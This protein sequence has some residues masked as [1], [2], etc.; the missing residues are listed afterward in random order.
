MSR[1]LF[2]DSAR[3]AMRS[4]IPMKRRLA[5]ALL[6]AGSSALWAKGMG[7]GVDARGLVSAVRVKGETVE[8]QLSGRLELVQFR[9]QTRSTNVLSPRTPIHIAGRQTSLCFVMIDD[10]SW[11]PG[12][13]RAGQIASVLERPAREKR[14]LRIELSDATV[15][16]EGETAE[17][18]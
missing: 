12:P 11:A 4:W 14:P 3:R 17:V 8:F 10:P 7:V 6:L 2:D 15:H 18:V 9:G 1:W 16:F 5:A 13:C